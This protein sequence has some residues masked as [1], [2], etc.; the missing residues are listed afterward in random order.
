MDFS[1]VSTHE[2]YEQVLKLRR[3]AYVDSGK[4]PSAT[5]ADKCA[6]IF[7]SRARILVARYR[8]ET[9][10]SLRLVFPGSM[11]KI[12][13]EDHVSLPASFP[14]RE[15]LVEITRVCTHPRFR[16]SDL[17]KL[18]FAQATKAVVESKRRYVVG[19]SNME[20]L[21]IY[22]RIGF[23]PTDIFFKHQGFNG[24]EH[25]VFAGDVTRVI[26]GLDIDPITWNVM[27]SD[28]ARFLQEHKLLEMDAS[29]ALRIRAFKLLSPIARIWAPR[30]RARKKI[31]SA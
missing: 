5:S 24:Q 21:P 10:G 7:D 1:Y 20:H 22:K 17:L 26:S 3:D 16:G 2:D 18:L 6:D 14:P 31:A 9:V 19:S 15:E 11:D 23:K 25:V 28:V 30:V 12:E 13:Q 29:T 27:Y 4:L 8:G